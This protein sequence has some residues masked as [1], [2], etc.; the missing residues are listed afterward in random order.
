MKNEEVKAIEEFNFYELFWNVLKDEN[1]ADIACMLH[2]ICEYMFEGKY[3]GFDEQKFNVI[4]A[5]LK[6]ILSLQR[7]AKLNGKK[8][9]KYDRLWRHF[10][11]KK[12]YYDKLKLMN[13]NDGGAYIR[14]ICEQAFEGK[15]AKDLPPQAEKFY[16]LARLT[17]DI[18]LERNKAG[19]KCGKSK[20][21]NAVY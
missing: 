12:S 3:T 17:L 5:D 1:N 18:S 7:Q 6:D 4:W 20:V 8:A 15:I 19:S 13:L 11:F 21:K 10:A 2:Q 14:A 16:S 9:S